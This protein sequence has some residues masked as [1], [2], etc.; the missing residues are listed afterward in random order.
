M[1]RSR[2]VASQ[3]ARASAAS[4]LSLAAATVSRRLADAAPAAFPCMSAPALVSV[5]H[6]F[7]RPCSAPLQEVACGSAASLEPD[8]Q[9]EDS[10]GFVI[11]RRPPPAG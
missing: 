5:S 2:V 10:E 8:V 4:S 3:P 9:W 11:A 1:S 6:V 7:P